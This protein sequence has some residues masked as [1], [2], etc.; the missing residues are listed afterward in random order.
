MSVSR[1]SKGTRLERW[2]AC[3]LVVVVLPLGAAGPDRRLADAAQKHD[4]TAVR[5][6]VKEGADVNGRLPDGATAL[7]WATHW[8]DIETVKLLLGAGADVNAANDFGVT[9]LSMACAAANLVMADALLR[10]G[11]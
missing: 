4:W 5:A 11:A 10:A 2:A 9:P 6:L 3:L 1:M 8:D 7:H